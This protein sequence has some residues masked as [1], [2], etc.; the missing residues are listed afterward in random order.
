MRK[1]ITTVMLMALFAI[2]A[3]CQMLGCAPAD[4]ADHACCHKHATP[5]MKCP[6]GLLEQAKA[7]AALAHGGGAAPVTRV[8]I[9]AIS[10]SPRRVQTETRLPNRAGSYLRNRILLI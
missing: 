8:S 5:K 1:A 6:H 3:S 4:A 10:E 2:M 7:G 9:P